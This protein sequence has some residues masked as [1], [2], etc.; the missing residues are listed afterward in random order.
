MSLRWLLVEAILSMEASS[1]HWPLMEKS[2]CRM[3]WNGE[4][5][6]D[7]SMFW[8]HT[9]PSFTV[10]LSTA[11]IMLLVAWTLWHWWHSRNQLKY[12][13]WGPCTETDGQEFIEEMVEKKNQRMSNMRNVTLSFFIF[14][15]DIVTSTGAQ[16]SVPAHELKDPLACGDRPTEAGRVDGRWLLT[17]DDSSLLLLVKMLRRTSKNHALY[18]KTVSSVPFTRESQVVGRFDQ[19]FYHISC[20][21]STQEHTF[22]RIMRFS[23][24][25]IIE[26]FYLQNFE[27]NNAH[28]HQD[29]HCPVTITSIIT[30]TMTNTIA[31]E[32]NKPPQPQPSQ[33][34]GPE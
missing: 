19:Y 6:S 15:Q 20:R 12:F 18:L 31:L 14:N 16:L 25:V 17:T 11:S 13:W 2:Q 23:I 5:Q 33:A 4:S 3:D 7:Q 30:S 29:P 28:E 24:F 21:M 8:F 10:R 1:S 26:P 32:S 9:F 34:P 22:V 27:T